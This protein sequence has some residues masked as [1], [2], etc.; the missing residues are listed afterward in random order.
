MPATPGATSAHGTHMKRQSLADTIA[1]FLPKFAVLLGGGGSVGSGGAFAVSKSVSDVRS[2]A[3]VSA[4][5]TFQFSSEIVNYDPVDKEIYLSLDFEWVPGKVDSLLEVGMGNVNL[6]C[7]T[8]D[9]QPPK[10][11]PI[12][13]VGANWT[14]TDDG[15]GRPATCA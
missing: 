14:M 7:K 15:E 10:D 13:Y 3:Y 8:F 4:K 2:G 1:S 9:F 12:T 11:K 6:D 5:D